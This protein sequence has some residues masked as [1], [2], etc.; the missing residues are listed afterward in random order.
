MVALSA[1]WMVRD[2]FPSVTSRASSRVQGIQGFVLFFANR[3]ATNL[4][5]KVLSP[6]RGWIEF[7]SD[8]TLE[9]S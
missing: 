4:H 8:L 9:P 2:F 7:D 5:K 1:L 3:W 6:E